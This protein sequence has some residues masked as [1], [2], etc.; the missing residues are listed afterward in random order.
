MLIGFNVIFVFV[1]N[2]GI[3]QRNKNCKIQS[4][5]FIETNMANYVPSKNIF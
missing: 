5:P 2:V 3:K 1:D 4:Q